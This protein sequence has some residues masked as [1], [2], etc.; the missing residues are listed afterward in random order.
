MAPNTLWSYERLF[1]R[2]TLTANQNTVY[3]GSPDSHPRR[4]GEYGHRP[5]GDGSRAPKTTVYTVTQP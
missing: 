1:H 2:G 3:T 5:Y 4:V